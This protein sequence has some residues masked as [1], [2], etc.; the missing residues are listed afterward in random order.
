MLDD[1]KP[2]NYDTN[3][4]C[5]RFFKG[6]SMNDITLDRYIGANMCIVRGLRSMMYVEKSAVGVREDTFVWNEARI[7]V[8]VIF[9]L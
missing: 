8:I 4:E 2:R 7:V 3:T 9:S 1:D 5:A 6:E